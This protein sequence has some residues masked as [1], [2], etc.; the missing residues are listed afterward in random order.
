[1]RNK[2]FVKAP[3]SA[4]KKKGKENDIGISHNFANIQLHLNE[5]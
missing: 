1:L 4:P 2:P 5:I 3:E